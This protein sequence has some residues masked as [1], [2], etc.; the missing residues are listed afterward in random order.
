[1]IKNEAPALPHY[2]QLRADQ[3][4]DG[5]LPVST[6]STMRRSLWLILLSASTTLAM[7]G[8][9]LG[10]SGRGPVSELASPEGPA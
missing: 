3:D 2:A 5:V 4:H 1:M 6:S 10:P 9:R 8:S 7:M